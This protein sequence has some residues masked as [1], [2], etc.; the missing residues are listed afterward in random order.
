MDLK[1]AVA[2]TGVVLGAFAGAPAAFA[3]DDQENPT[4]VRIG[5]TKVESI[6]GYGTSDG[7]PMTPSD[8]VHAC[9]YSAQHY[10]VEELNT[11]WFLVPPTGRPLTATIGGFQ[12]LIVTNYAGEQLFQIG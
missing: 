12:P 11:A 10:Y 1:I 9:F 3:G 7:E 4:S 2:L 8:P 6:D 5:E